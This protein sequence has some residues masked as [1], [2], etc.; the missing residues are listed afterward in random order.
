M[1]VIWRLRVKGLEGPVAV[2]VED[3][4]K[5]AEHGVDISGGVPVAY[6]DPLCGSVSPGCIH[7]AASAK[8]MAEKCVPVGP[9]FPSKWGS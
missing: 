4:E 2:F 8:L 1:H 5:A 3:G 7:W 6:R 9:S